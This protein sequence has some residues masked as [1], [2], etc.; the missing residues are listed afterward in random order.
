M[1]FSSHIVLVNVTG[2]K[3]KTYSFHPFISKA[4]TMPFSF[5]FQEISDKTKELL[6][7]IKAFSVPDE[8]TGKPYITMELLQSRKM[9]KTT[10]NFLYSLSVCEGMVKLQPM[11][12]WP[13]LSVLIALDMTSCSK[14]GIV[15]FFFSLFILSVKIIN[16]VST[17][18]FY[19]C[20][21]SE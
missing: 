8:E 15:F 2:T 1:F 12:I 13:K 14:R 6:N 3:L 7:N 21:F 18:Y 10:E 11:T 5:S 4:F 9:P 17:H 19:K 20:Y 16:D